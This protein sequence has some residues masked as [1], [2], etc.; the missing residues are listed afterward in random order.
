MNLPDDRKYTKS[1]LWLKA[2][3]EKVFWVGL[4]KPATNQAEKFLF[5]DLPEE[6]STIEENQSIIEYES[7]KRV[8]ELN[9]P[10]EAKVIQ[11]HNEVSK[12]PDE[13]TDNPYD[14]WLLK[15]KPHE[16]FE[17]KLLSHKEAE[18]Y[19]EKQM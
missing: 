19:Y 14:T 17:E 13:L 16:D 11:I 1:Y 2:E 3:K 10:R 12:D 18:E 7:M 15:I 9:I 4:A 6:G 5:I 8:G